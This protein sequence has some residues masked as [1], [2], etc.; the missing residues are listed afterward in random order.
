MTVWEFLE[1]RDERVEATQA[2]YEWSLNYHP[3]E[4]PFSCLLDLVGWS[5]EHLGE[6]CY[7]GGRL[8]W[9]EIRLLS[10]ALREWV[11]DP[12]RV[13]DWIDR[14]IALEMND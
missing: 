8:G 13:D 2:L 12:P 11:Y 10:D 7:R 3:G 5:D 9:S 4:G 14:V 1:E 6:P